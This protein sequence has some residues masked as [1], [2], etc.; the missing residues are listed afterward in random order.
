VI[1]FPPKAEPKPEPA[2]VSANPFMA[3]LLN[4]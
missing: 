3:A 1:N 4:V 2:P